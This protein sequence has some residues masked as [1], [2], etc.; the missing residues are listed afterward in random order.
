MKVVVIAARVSGTSEN[1]KP[2]M[3]CR[4]LLSRTLSQSEYADRSLAR[5]VSRFKD[6]YPA[7]YQII[8]DV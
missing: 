6:M 4:I 1:G 5:K 7:T 3:Q 8:W 2:H